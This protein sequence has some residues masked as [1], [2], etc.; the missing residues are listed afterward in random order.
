[1]KIQTNMLIIKT[2]SEEQ[3]LRESK[4]FCVFFILLYFIVRYGMDSILNQIHAYASYSFEV[5]FILVVTSLYYK[6]LKFSFKIDIYYLLQ[7][8]LACILGFGIFLCAK[9]FEILIPFDL[10]QKIIAFCWACFRRIFIS[11]SVLEFI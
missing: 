6:D 7:C 2:M 11:T 10:S 3:K 5:L 4:Q 1:M 9:V 8:F